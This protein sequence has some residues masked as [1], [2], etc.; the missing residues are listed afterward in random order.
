MSALL[1]FGLIVI[2]GL[3]FYEIY[4]EF[5]NALIT[6]SSTSISMIF[7]FAILSFCILLGIPFPTAIQILTQVKMDKHILWMYSI[8]GIMSVLVSVIATIFSMTYGFIA[9][10]RTG[11]FTYTILFI[12]SIYFFYKMK[13][14]PIKCRMVINI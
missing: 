6:Y 1:V 12:C 2:G 3:V 7:F 13:I 11:I 8:N 4:M 10:F 9:T 14:K 5:L